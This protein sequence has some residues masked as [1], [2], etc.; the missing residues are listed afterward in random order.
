MQDSIVLRNDTLLKLR[1]KQSTMTMR[2]FW[3]LAEQNS[4]HKKTWPIDK[5]KKY[6]LF[7]RIATSNPQPY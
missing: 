1:G 6:E 2:L 4:Y 5:I 7:E 3:F